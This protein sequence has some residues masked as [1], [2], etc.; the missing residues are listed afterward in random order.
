MLRKWKPITE[1]ADY[2]L[3]KLSVL[4]CQWER[5]WLCAAPL[6]LVPRRGWKP[7]DERICVR[8][9]RM[10]EAQRRALVGEPPIWFAPAGEARGQIPD[11]LVVRPGIYRVQVD[12]AIHD[13]VSVR[14]VVEA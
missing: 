14:Q 7:C 3:L 4:T 13:S 10:V 8:C 5:C 1:Q 12:L 2:D 9:A 11:A 6:L